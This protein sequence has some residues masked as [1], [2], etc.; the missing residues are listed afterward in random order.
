MP[1]KT[2]DTQ[3]EVILS[4]RRSGARTV[5]KA[6]QSKIETLHAEYATQ[7]DEF[8]TVIKVLVEL[9]EFISSMIERDKK[10]KGGLWN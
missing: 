7:T 4:A 2:I 10:R 9:S 1:P 3:S 8:Q 5:R 6:I